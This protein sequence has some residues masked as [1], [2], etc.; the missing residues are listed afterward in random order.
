MAPHEVA[1]LPLA[2]D[3]AETLDV[4]RRLHDDLTAAGVD[5]LLDDRDARPGVKF[6]DADLIGFPLRVVIGSRGLKNGQV[7]AKWR[8]QRQPQMLDL[9]TAAS[10]IAG[11]INDRRRA[12]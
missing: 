3:D 4:A 5:V 2:V 11:W 7:E 8:D 12:T 10:T 1:L 6:N 9:A